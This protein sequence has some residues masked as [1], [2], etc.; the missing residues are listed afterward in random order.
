[1]IC[2]RHPAAAAGIH[3][4]RR[5]FPR[6]RTKQNTRAGAARRS[7]GIGPGTLF[8]GRSAP[9]RIPA[10]ALRPTAARRS[11]TRPRVFDRSRHLPRAS[12]FH[13]TTMRARRRLFIAPP[14]C[15]ARRKTNSS[16]ECIHHERALLFLFMRCTRATNHHLYSLL[17]LSLFPRRCYHS[18]G[19]RDIWPLGVWHPRNRIFFFLHIIC[20]IG[21]RAEPLSRVSQAR[22]D[23]LFTGRKRKQSGFKFHSN[24][25]AERLGGASTLYR[26]MIELARRRFNPIRRALRFVTL[27][28]ML[29]V[30]FPMR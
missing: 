18:T 17:S 2:S 19:N 8:S 22:P 14:Q 10:S 30:R 21:G 26:A 11:W 23:A 13:V 25:C 15:R 16:R 6:C 7:R 9:L 5:A 4:P 12:P 3:R 28:I 1:M 29:I 24:E 27:I 20:D